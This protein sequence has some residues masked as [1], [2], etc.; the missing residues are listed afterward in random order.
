M[1][2]ALVLALAVLLPVVP[3]R[4]QE[5]PPGSGAPAGTTGPAGYRAAL[6]LLESGDTAAALARLREV[7]REHDGYGPAFLRLGSVLS[8]RAGEVQTEYG[9]RVAAERALERAYRLLGDDPEV[10][11]EWGLLLRKQHVQTDARRV[12]ERAWEAAERGGRRLG[13]RARAKLHYGLGRIYEVWWEDWRD[14]I[15]LTPVATGGWRCPE[16]DAPPGKGGGG[17]ALVL[18]VCP[19]R[20]DGVASRAPALVDLGSEER[21]RMVDHFRLAVDADPGH[22]DAAVRLMGHLADAGEWSEYL[23]VATGLRAAAPDDFRSPLFLA[24]GLH[25]RGRDSLAARYFRE[26]LDRMPPG[27]R[28][29]F[30]DV[31]LL[32]PTDVR[33]RYAALDS[34]DR[35]RTADLLFRARDP[36]YL[37]GVEERRLEH[38]ARLAW[39][40]LEYSAPASGLRG[41]E[42]E[43]GR[44]FVR[45]G[46]PR[47]RMQCCYGDGFRGSHARHVLWSYG[48]EGPNFAFGR[49]LTYRRARMT[50][51]SKLLADDLAAVAPE[52]YDPVTVTAVRGFPHQLAHFR[53]D[54]PRYARV[55][56][57]ARPPADS[58]SVAPG[59]SVETGLFV[60]DGTHEPLWE[61]RR[62]LTATE[63][64]PPVRYGFEL[65]AGRFRY[66]LEA[67]R[68]GPDSVPR[69]VARS[70]EAVD[71]AVFPRGT[72]AISD[73]V[74]ADTVVPRT[75][76]PTRRDELAV[77]PLASLRLPRLRAVHL[78]VEVYGLSTGPDGLGRYR[79][80]L[81][82]EDST[83]RNVIARL[84]RGAG[85]LLGG[86]DDETRVAWERAAPVV[87]DR[88][89]DW[90]RA[91]LP[92]LDPGAYVV[93]LRI[94]DRT[95]GDV[96]ERTRR[97]EIVGAPE[98]DG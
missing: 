62:T 3:A 57:Y 73:I 78:V 49:R 44:I 6:G 55:E 92:V 28:R 43:R 42:S 87:D 15:D 77:A 33:D 91:E 97:F 86:G 35:A 16:L 94:R 67:R 88:S 4:A 11:L 68:T 14:L 54:D 71:V 79:A 40:E 32:L 23:D 81:A 48:P 22:V 76:S 75:A 47:A 2:T 19:D 95:T 18:V 74:L 25:R 93:R 13:P 45:Y 85:E 96:V 37:T 17:L 29:A 64:V 41:W 65:P 59:D 98:P 30:G 20:W 26:A 53:G 72:F 66:G 90:L 51:E 5:P 70:R 36:L 89:V 27:D 84:V 38:Y 1:V 39:A 50:G 82:V 58:L 61:T 46:W 34:A 7:T 12:L 60:F 8:A 10:L 56:V 83:E 80:E 9:G 21:E 69:P 31:E 63:P 52:A 24:L